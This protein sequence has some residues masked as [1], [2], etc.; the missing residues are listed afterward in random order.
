MA[1]EASAG[2][3]ERS[4]Q[5]GGKRRGFPSDAK[6]GAVQKLHLGS[7]FVFGTGHTIQFQ[8]LYVLQD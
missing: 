7:P 5:D 6:Q 2:G 1:A 8:R 4:R 3:S